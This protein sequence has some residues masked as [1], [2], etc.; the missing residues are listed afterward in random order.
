MS[1]NRTTG[2]PPPGM[3]TIPTIYFTHF[4][5]LPIPFV[6]SE[7]LWKASL[8]LSQITP[9]FFPYLT[10]FIDVCLALNAQKKM[11]MF[12]QSMTFKCSSREMDKVICIWHSPNVLCVKFPSSNY[13]KWQSEFFYWW[14]ICKKNY[15]LLAPHLRRYNQEICHKIT[16]ACKNVGCTF[17]MPSAIPGTRTFSLKV[18]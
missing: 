12:L 10:G 14:K 13:G 5:V 16:N 6:M 17:G 8:P 3:L 7:I 9:Y 15:V 4:C 11:T 18:C 2:N 1:R